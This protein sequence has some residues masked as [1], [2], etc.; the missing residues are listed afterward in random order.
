MGTQAKSKL[1]V[2]LR[3][4]TYSVFDYSTDIYIFTSRLDFS[5]SKAVLYQSLIRQR[6]ETAAV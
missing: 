1:G 4:F 3:H 2:I 6:H 5:K